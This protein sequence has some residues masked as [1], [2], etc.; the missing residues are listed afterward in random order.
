MKLRGVNTKLTKPWEVKVYSDS[1]EG[2]VETKLVK[3]F[4]HNNA[5]EESDVIDL[6]PLKVKYIKVEGAGANLGMFERTH[7]T[8]KTLYIDLHRFSAHVD[9][10]SLFRD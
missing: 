3:T 4:H 10:F 5:N 1:T 2:C 8:P 6:K 9:N 7:S